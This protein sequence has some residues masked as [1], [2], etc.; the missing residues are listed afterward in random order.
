MSLLIWPAAKHE[1]L[2]CFFVLLCYS[3]TSVSPL[4]EYAK[5]PEPLEQFTLSQIR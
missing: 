1:L 4:D 5:P 2:S 3:F